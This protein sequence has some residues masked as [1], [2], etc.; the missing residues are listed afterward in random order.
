MVPEEIA[1]ILKRYRDVVP[2]EL[3]FRL[4]LLRDI[5]HAIDLILGSV[6][7]N[8]AH[9][10]MSPKQHKERKRQVQDLLEKGFVQEGISLFAALLVPKKDG[11]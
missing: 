9:Y 4:P 8:K 10:K 11:S 5:Q 7:P 1:P 6:L 3:P 2:V